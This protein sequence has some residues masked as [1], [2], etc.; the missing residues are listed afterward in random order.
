LSINRSK[1]PPAPA[2]ETVAESNPDQTMERALPMKVV[3]PATQFRQSNPGPAPLTRFA[4]TDDALALN[5]TIEMLVSPQAS[6]EQ[7]QAAWKQLK[8]MGKLDQAISDLEQRTTNEPQKA[9]YAAALGQAYLKKCALTRDVR[10]QAILA[11][12]ADQTLDVALG[13]DPSNWEARYTK[14]IGMS[15]WPAQL[16]KG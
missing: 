9:E 15:Y 13:L 12:K 6:F 2:V 4:A 3:I 7:K 10:E 11:M 1:T 16:N 8:E 5:Q 14:A